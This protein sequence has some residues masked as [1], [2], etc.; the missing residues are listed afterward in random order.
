MTIFLQKVWP[1]S[2]EV[3]LHGPPKVL[4]VLHQHK[5]CIHCVYVYV[6]VGG[7]GKLGV[8]GIRIASHTYVPGA[9]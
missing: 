5:S 3:R 1:P 2:T 4:T 7:G 6:C 9:D 8:T